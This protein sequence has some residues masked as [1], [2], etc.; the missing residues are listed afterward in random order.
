MTHLEEQLGIPGS[1]PVGPGAG[2]GRREGAGVPGLEGAYRWCRRM[3]RERDPAIY[4]LTALM[5]RMLWPACWALW[6]AL[7][8]VD[9]IV[10]SR[11]RQ[12]TERTAALQAWVSALDVELATGNS[13]DM[14][15]RA[16]V[17]TIV[18]WGLDVADLR[19]SFQV[20][21]GD[22]H[23]APLV[24]WDDWRA[25]SRGT[26]SAWARQILVLLDRAGVDMSFELRHGEAIARFLD[27]VQLVDNLVDLAEDL[28][29]QRLTI[30]AEVLDRFPG[31]AKDLPQRRW[32]MPVQGVLADLV[33]TARQWVDQPGLGVGWHPGP[34]ILLATTS[35]V[36]LARLDAIAAA[37]PGLLH[38]SPEP[39]LITRWRL[40]APARVRIALAWKLTTLS[41]P[42]ADR[43]LPATPAPAGPPP[44]Q[45]LPPRLR[46]DGVRAPQIAADRIPQHVAIV[47][48]GNGRW[49]QQRG[50]PRPEGHRAGI[51][52]VHDVVHGALE[53]GLSHLT[54]Y[55]FSTENWKRDPREVTL[56]FA[57][58]DEEL[59]S[60]PYLD[61]GVRLRWLG[62]PDR[63]PRELVQTLQ[64]NE[65]ASRDQRTLTLTLCVNYGGRAEILHGAAAVARSVLAGELDTERITEGEF[66]RHLPLPD[67]PDVDLLW[68]TG[69]EQRTSNFLP[70][71]STY[72]ELFFTASLWPDVD[73]RD[74]WDAIAE[75]ARR[76]RRYGAATG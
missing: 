21:G 34:A 23:P 41:G 39:G 53:I 66:G 12:P 16:L 17:D 10:D 72:A 26:D 25:R 42:P 7:V 4:A 71:H 6:A 44:G 60:T 22:V 75:Y 50:L 73:R 13:T 51:E 52:A 57:M 62:S 38:A 36:F 28:G 55:A 18:R 49:A 54:L 76:R 19:A 46:A 8:T 70:W 20:L 64:R 9:D 29:H 40:L 61:H 3:V 47:M 63:L 43:P 11:T 2:D 15:R 5:P 1:E 32:T 24:T 68:R 27:G 74:L 56:L 48:D 67:L 35:R 65:T 58:L 45:V 30:P 37:G 33:R 14:V 31:A 59:R 69:A